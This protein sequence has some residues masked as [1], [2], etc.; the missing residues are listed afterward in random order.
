MQS[1]VK[2]LNPINIDGQ[3]EMV[4]LVHVKKNLFIYFSLKQCVVHFCAFLCDKE[5]NKLW[6]GNYY[7]VLLGF[8]V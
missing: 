6:S 2:G 1:I 3:R 8:L 4:Q 5:K 7:K